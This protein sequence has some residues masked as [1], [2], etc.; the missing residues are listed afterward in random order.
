LGQVIVISVLGAILSP[1]NE[2]LDYFIS[3]FKS[4]CYRLPSRP[5]RPKPPR[6]SPVSSPVVHTVKKS[7]YG[8]RVFKSQT[9]YPK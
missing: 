1:C 5:R 3:L 8:D 7:N 2:G 6:Q 9:L 4:F